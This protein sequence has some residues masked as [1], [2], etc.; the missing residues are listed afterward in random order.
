[1]RVTWFAEYLPYA[2]NTFDDV[3]TSLVFHY[4]PTWNAALMEVHR[5]L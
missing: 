2:A 3:V 1:M 4:L 5:V